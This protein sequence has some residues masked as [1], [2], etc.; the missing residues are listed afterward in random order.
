MPAKF[1]F[2]NNTLHINFELS[3]TKHS[4]RLSSWENGIDICYL[5]DGKIEK[6]NKYIKCYGLS[7][8]A[9][10][11]NSEGVK[12]F[13]T[14][15]EKIRKL[16]VD[17][18]LSTGYGISLS[19]LIAMSIDRNVRALF[20]NDK[21]IFWLLITTAILNKWSYVKVFRICRMY[22]EAA[23]SACDLP[24]CD[25]AVQLTPLAANICS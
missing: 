1:E 12:W 4:V 24:T 11:N 2:N 22:R 18:E 16:I 9:I 8:L 15:P 17:F 7:L 14:I 5:I 13:N 20:L 25:F 21:N 6:D 23:L 3:G 19:A 10:I